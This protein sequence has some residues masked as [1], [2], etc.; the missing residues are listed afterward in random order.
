MIK[1]IYKEVEPLI[2]VIIE[3]QQFPVAL[4]SCSA[5]ACLTDRTNILN[6]I[7]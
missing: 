5:E 4:E 1:P 2:Q 3:A 6:N 7:V